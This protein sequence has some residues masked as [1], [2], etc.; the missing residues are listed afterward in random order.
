M[1]K[2]LNKHQTTDD[3]EFPAKRRRK[4]VSESTGS[5]E[6]LGDSSS[7]IG[8]SD[9]ESSIDDDSSDSDSESSSSSESLLPPEDEQEESPPP[10]VTI[11]TEQNPP[12]G[13]LRWYWTQRHRLFSCYEK[14][15]WMTDD[16]WFEVTPEKVAAYGA[17]PLPLSPILCPFH[18]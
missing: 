5:S 1:T 13:V 10:G 9:R 4:E 8:D 3:I 15:I 16:S 11:Y 6:P 2:S 17:L 12:E 18:R 14:G 7:S